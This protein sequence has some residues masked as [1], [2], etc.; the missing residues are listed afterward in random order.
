MTSGRVLGSSHIGQAWKLVNL[1]HV[2]NP[3]IKHWAL[4]L[5]PFLAISVKSG[6]VY[7]LSLRI[8]IKILYFLVKY[9][10]INY[11]HMMLYNRDR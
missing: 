6:M 7:N 1:Y 10:N 8:V 9:Y 5:F 3:T 4:F 11:E 2:A